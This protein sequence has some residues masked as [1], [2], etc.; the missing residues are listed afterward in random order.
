MKVTE[1][2]KHYTED[3]QQFWDFEQAL[4]KATQDIF[5][6]YCD[7]HKSHEKKLE[8]VPWSMRPCVFKLHS[9][10]LEHLKPR[11]EK[12]YM[13]HVVELVNNLALYEQKRLLVPQPTK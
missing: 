12:V 7:V 5:Q 8:D 2:L 13:K 10:F 4:R 3:R 9:H 6:A 11:S 1:Y